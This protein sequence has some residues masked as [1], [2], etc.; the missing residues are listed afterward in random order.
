MYFLMQTKHKH[1]FI[2]LY[3]IGMAEISDAY[4]MSKPEQI[5][6]RG[7]TQLDTIHD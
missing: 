6:T 4:T 2:H 1:H 5:K 7:V 3:P